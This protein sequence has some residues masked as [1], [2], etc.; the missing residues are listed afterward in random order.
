MLVNGDLIDNLL[1]E[2]EPA[3]DA[4]KSV[5]T[6]KAIVEAAAATDTIALPIET[7]PRHDNQV[8]FGN[9]DRL[10]VGR[11]T[12][13]VAVLCHSA[14]EIGHGDGHEMAAAPDNAGHDDGFVLLKRFENRVGGVDLARQGKKE[15]DDR[16]LTEFGTKAEIFASPDAFFMDLLSGQLF[17][18]RPQL[19]S[20]KLF[21]HRNRFAAGVQKREETMFSAYR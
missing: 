2:G 5:M 13:P 8:D 16:C 15:H 19:I 1:L 20:S 11:V 14:V 6:E 7:K 10:S 3:S 17:Q 18:D 12:Q 21:Y 9:G 4:S